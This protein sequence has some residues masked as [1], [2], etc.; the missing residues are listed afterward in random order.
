M[1]LFKKP[2][3]NS[4]AMPAD[5]PAGENETEPDKPF[6]FLEDNGDRQPFELAGE[7]SADW[8]DNE[9]EGQLSVDVYQTKNEIIVKSTIAGVKPDDLDI[10]VNG[11]MVTIR[12]QRRQETEID[13][14]DYFFRECY[15]GGFSRSLILPCEV[16][17]DHI[18]ANLKNGVL[19]IILP[20][21][22]PAKAINVQIEEE[23]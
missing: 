14:K 9:D 13:E 19:T 8:L 12:G 18:Q 21:A 7:E 15:W 22:K 5:R 23:E 6:I 11:D 20:K 1:K 16:K 10:A 17:T 4:P 3:S 2:K